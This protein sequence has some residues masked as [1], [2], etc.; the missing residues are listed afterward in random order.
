MGNVT[1]HAISVLDPLTA[2]ISS[3]Q[4]TSGI[5]D[6]LGAT[7]LQI[8]LPAT[9][10]GTALT[11][12]TS[13]DGSTFQEYRNINDVVV[14]ITCTQAKNYGLAAQDF[15]PTRYIKIVSNAAESADRAIR[16]V[17]KSI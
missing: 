14:S 17:P 1:Q 15:F 13:S 6:T 4:T 8:E 12:L 11:F 10:D 2:T 7:I 16:L 3:G 5:V 9:F